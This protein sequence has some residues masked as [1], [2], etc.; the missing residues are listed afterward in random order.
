MKCPQCGSIQLRRTTDSDNRITMI[1]RPFIVAVQCYRC[2]HEF[3]RPS[4][5]T[6]DL[7][8]TPQYHRARRAA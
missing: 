8:A 5:M 2:G 7:P 6:E 3:Y 4:V 1:V